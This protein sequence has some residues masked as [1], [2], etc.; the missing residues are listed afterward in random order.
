MIFAE[1]IRDILRKTPKKPVT[2]EIGEMGTREFQALKAQESEPTFDIF[3]IFP[4]LIQKL[5]D[6]GKK[7]RRLFMMRDHEIMYIFSA[8][9]HIGWKDGQL[10]QFTLQ[11]KKEIEKK[12]QLLLNELLIFR[13]TESTDEFPETRLGW[14]LQEVEEETW[15]SRPDNLSTQ[16]S[17]QVKK[18]KMESEQVI[19]V[20]RRFD[21]VVL[22]K[23]V[24][25]D[26][27]ESAQI[28]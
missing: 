11:E 9:I 19:I 8:L 4:D 2:K 5:N 7:K 23:P 26:T 14:A 24:H 13:S 15:P 17:E 25:P 20:Q 3:D 12:A 21:E 16:L 18:K 1:I 10:S 6:L 22:F 28:E 27:D